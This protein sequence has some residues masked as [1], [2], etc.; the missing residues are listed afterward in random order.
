MTI[1]TW[2]QGITGELQNTTETT[3]GRIVKDKVCRQV[4][5]SES[6]DIKEKHNSRKRQIVATICLAVRERRGE[7]KLR[8][9]KSDRN[10]KDEMD[11]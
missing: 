1:T 9:G 3:G 5:G 6:R 11:E 4:E 7:I 10:A 8:I 2:P